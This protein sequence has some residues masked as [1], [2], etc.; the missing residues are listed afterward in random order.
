MIKRILLNQATTFHRFRRAV[1]GDV[2][3]EDGTSR[4]WEYRPAIIDTFEQLEAEAERVRSMVSLL[5][6]SPVIVTHFLGRHP[7]RPS[8]A[9]GSH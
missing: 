4:T 6:L 8:P 7:P 3:A 9:R 5:A 2:A 1:F